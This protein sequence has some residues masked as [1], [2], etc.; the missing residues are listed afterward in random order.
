MKVRHLP[1]DAF[2]FLTLAERDRLLSYGRE[3]HFEPGGVILREGHR[4]DGIHV[5]INGRVAV[6]KERDGIGGVLDELRP[7]SVFGEVSYLAGIPPSASVVARTAVDVFV[8]EDLDQLLA[9]DIAVAAGFYRSIASLLARRLRLT[10]EEHA[11][12]ATTLS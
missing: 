8:L 9:A 4:S 6:E 7:G 5:L 1:E 12:A 2:P 10:T 11:R 3:E